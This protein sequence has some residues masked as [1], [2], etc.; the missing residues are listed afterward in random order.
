MGTPPLVFKYSTLLFSW[1]HLSGWAWVSI[2]GFAYLWSLDLL[3]WWMVTVDKKPLL[4]P[5]LMQAVQ[6]QGFARGCSSLVREENSHPTFPQFLGW[7]GQGEQ[8]EGVSHWPQPGCFRQT[9]RPVAW[10][11][12]KK[13]PPSRWTVSP[14]STNFNMYIFCLL[15]KNFFLGLW[16]LYWSILDLQHCVS[17]RCTAKWFSYTYSFFFRFFSHIGY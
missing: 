7:R 17:F 10:L 1:I 15:L 8:E 16:I 3:G 2:W 9:P 12:Q 11:P 14:L 5:G 4:S 13:V 6:G